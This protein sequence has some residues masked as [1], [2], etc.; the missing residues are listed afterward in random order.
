MK[1][2][3]LIKDRKRNEMIRKTDKGNTQPLI[4]YSGLG[5]VSQFRLIVF[6]QEIPVYA[7]MTAGI[8]SFYMNYK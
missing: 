1:P 5:P 6:Y 8:F 7:G 3:E 4:H 2:F